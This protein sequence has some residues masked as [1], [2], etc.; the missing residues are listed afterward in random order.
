MAIEKAMEIKKTSISEDIIE[1]AKAFETIKVAVDELLN[2][3]QIGTVDECRAAREKQIPKEPI[4]DEF[5][6]KC[7]P[8]CGRCACELLSNRHMPYCE[9]CGQALKWGD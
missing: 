3:R 6:S 7:C 8:N 5:R 2:Y 1:Q 9:Y 4:D